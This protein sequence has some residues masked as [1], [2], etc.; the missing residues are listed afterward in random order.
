ME[1]IE[2]MIGLTT[3]SISH[4]S[5]GNDN[6]KYDWNKEP[7]LPVEDME[8]TEP[9][10]V[11]IKIVIGLVLGLTILVSIL[12]NIMVCLAISSDRRLRRLGNLFLASLALADLFVGCLVMTFALANDLMEYWMFGP[13]LCEIWIAFDISCC[14]CSIL[15]LCAISLD[16]FVH[17]KDPM[18]YNRWM[19]KKIIFCAVSGIWLV[20]GF[21]SFVPISL[22]WHKPTANTDID[23]NV[24]LITDILDDRPQCALD[25]TPTYALV[26]STISFY[27]PCI[28]MVALYAKLYAI[29]QKH[30]KSIKSMTKPIHVSGQTYNHHIT[31]HKAAITLG[32]IMGT[33]LACWTPFFC[34]NIVAAYC[35]T[36]I[37][38]LAFKVLTW[39]GYFNSS[40]NPAIYSIFNTEFREAFRRIIISYIARDQCCN[41]NSD[42]RQRCSSRSGADHCGIGGGPT[43]HCQ[44]YSPSPHHIITTNMNN[45]TS[46]DIFPVSTRNKIEINQSNLSDGRITDI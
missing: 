29:C 23:K 5:E 6:F 7:E 11:Y 26:S 45:M 36:C 46:S 33:F 8:Y 34:M 1:S 42:I 21:V 28:I 30:V 12:G 20:S 39:L 41:N 13:Q 4:P 43:G 37:P 2:K 27:L 16:R 31:E 10:S 17:I 38:S 19:N 40:L 15:N 22:G 24:T 44:D 18:S 9:F 32:V 3:K 25:L 14:T 35:K